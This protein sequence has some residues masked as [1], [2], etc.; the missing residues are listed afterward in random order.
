[1][2]RSL[3]GGV[4]FKN[5]FIKHYYLFIFREGK[6]GREGEKHQIVVA[7]HAPPIGD[8]ACDPGMCPR[9][10]IEPVTLWFI[11]QHSLH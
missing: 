11:G 8:L 9:L 1:M 2:R 6:G 3:E 4:T 5:I 7:S 10:R